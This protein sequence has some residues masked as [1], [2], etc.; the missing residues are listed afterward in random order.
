ML[1]P[2]CEQ[3]GLLRSGDF[4]MQPGWYPDPDGIPGLRW[5]DGEQWTPNFSAV[6]QSPSPAPLLT[7]AP[8]R[9]RNPLFVVLA[10]LSGIPTTVFL[11][12]F[13]NG[14]SHIAVFLF[15]WSAMWTWVWWNLSGRW[16]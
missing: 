10:A 1:T 7:A 14:G 2:A 11:L 13:V 12:A 3:H 5:F 6:P 15:L 4:V 8:K 16:R 9:S